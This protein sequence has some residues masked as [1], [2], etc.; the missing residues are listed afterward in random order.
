MILNVFSIRSKSMLK[1]IEIINLF[2]VRPL[3]NYLDINLCNINKFLESLPHCIYI[4]L[5]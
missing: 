4:I 2:V 3:S 5:K 1:I